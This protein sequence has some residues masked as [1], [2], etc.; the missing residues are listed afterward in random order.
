MPSIGYAI[1]NNDA[2]TLR[3]LLN[4]YYYRAKTPTMTDKMVEN[5]KLQCIYSG[6]P[7]LLKAFKPFTTVPSQ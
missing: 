7:N 5:A 6:K 4:Q 1:N 3:I 2:G